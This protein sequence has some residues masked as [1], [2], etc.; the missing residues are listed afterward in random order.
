[1]CTT[2]SQSATPQVAPSLL[3]RQGASDAVIV[4]SGIDGSSARSV[5]SGTS[6]LHDRGHA[7][8]PKDH[9]VEVVVGAPTIEMPAAV[10]IEYLQ[11]CGD[12]DGQAEHRI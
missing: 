3:R 9:P 4:V 10:R 1:V 11:V 6:R 8:S 12:G 5:I 2:A 7:V